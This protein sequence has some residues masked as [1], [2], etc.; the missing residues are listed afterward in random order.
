MTKNNKRSYLFFILAL[1]I[2][3]ISEWVICLA[4]FPGLFEKS[5]PNIIVAGIL[6]FTYPLGWI[7]I[8][9]GKTARNGGLVIGLLFVVNI[10]LEEF[11]HWPGRNSSLV[12]TLASMFILFISFSIIG[13]LST[14]KNGNFLTGLKNSFGS[15]LPGTLIAVGFGFLIVFLFPVHMGAILKGYPGYEEFK[16]PVAF[17]F[18]LTF[19]NASD[20]MIQVPLIAGITG[21]AGSVLVLTLRRLK[22]KSDE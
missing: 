18:S 10:S 3:V 15:A 22:K 4:R 20:H 14:L 7:L 8:K 17:A 16:N 6:L 13:G 12:F 9:P 21:S 11:I 2:V 5:L 19:G 1:V